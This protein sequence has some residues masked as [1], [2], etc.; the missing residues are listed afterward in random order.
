M[1]KV[2]LKK[3]TKEPVKKETPHV[4]G[5]ESRTR[6]RMKRSNDMDAYLKNRSLLQHLKDKITGNDNMERGKWF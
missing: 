1:A 5:H 4:Q 6:A 3:E 2:K